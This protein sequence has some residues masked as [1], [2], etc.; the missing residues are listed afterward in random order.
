MA[1][2]S[3][4]AASLASSALSMATRENLYICGIVGA[5]IGALALPILNAATGG[6]G[7]GG[8]HCCGGAACG[9][10]CGAGWLLS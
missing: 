7:G 2:I 10:A 4:R 1:F 3:T 5:A 8:A 6:R 9:A